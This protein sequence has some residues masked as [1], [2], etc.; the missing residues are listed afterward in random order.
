MPY[1][2]ILDTSSYNCRGND[3]SKWKK[4]QRDEEDKEIGWTRER[5]KQQSRP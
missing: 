4:R 1:L 3:D 5:Q 2:V